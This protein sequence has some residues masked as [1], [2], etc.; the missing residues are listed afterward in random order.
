MKSEAHLSVTSKLNFHGFVAS[1]KLR[2]YIFDG[3]RKTFKN[4]LENSME[5]LTGKAFTRRVA[6]DISQVLARYFFF[7][8][9]FIIS[10]ARKYHRKNIDK[11]KVLCQSKKSYG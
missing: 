2:H 1:D 7:I 5:K 8:F 11:R 9:F 4:Y 6:D 3:R 10:L